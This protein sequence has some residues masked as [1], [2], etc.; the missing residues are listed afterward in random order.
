M[1]KT[2][3][4]EILQSEESNKE[5][6]SYLWGYYKW[7]VILSLFG[8]LVSGYLLVDWI[9]RPITYFHLTVLAPEVDF[10]EEEPLSQELNRLLEPEGANETAYA[11]FTPH[12]QMA[13]RFTA[14]FTAGEYDVILMDDFSFEEY[15]E[16]DT[17][18]EFRLSGL[19]DEDYYQPDHYDNPVGVDSSVIPLLEEYRTTDDLILVIPGNTTRREAIVEFFATQGFEFEFID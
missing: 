3:V 10:D 15:S 16:Y 9:N 17:M 6:F 5:K 14:Q 19:D 1:A 4:K 8:L 2:K 13:E 11:S 7:H 18:Q 12:G